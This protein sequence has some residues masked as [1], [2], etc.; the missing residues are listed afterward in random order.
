MV[1]WESR[2]IET[3]YLASNS[4]SFQDVSCDMPGSGEIDNEGEHDSKSKSDS[5]GL[6][7]SFDR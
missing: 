3:G 6:A 7:E 5:G 1:W 2:H 4:S